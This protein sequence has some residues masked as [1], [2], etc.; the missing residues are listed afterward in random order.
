MKWDTPRVLTILTGAG[1]FGI[2]ME[3]RGDLSGT[4]ARALVAAGAGAVL[5]LTI[6]LAQTRK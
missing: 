4:W 1:L 6:V 2:L 5:G 3:A